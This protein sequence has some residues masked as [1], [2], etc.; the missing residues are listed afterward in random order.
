[1]LALRVSP[2]RHLLGINTWTAFTVAAYFS[3][4]V[5]FT[6]ISLAPLIRLY[7]N[8]VADREHSTSGISANFSSTARML[9]GSSIP[10]D[11]EPFVEAPPQSLVIHRLYLRIIDT[12][13]YRCRRQEAR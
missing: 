2:D 1:V 11:N 4:L 5:K 13:A 7:H 9:L 3:A 8:G 6:G 12:D 10:V